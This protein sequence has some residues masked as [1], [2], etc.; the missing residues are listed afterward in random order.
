MSEA[1]QSQQGGLDHDG[2]DAVRVDVRGRA[3]VLEVARAS[4]RNRA[5]DTDRSTTVGNARGELAD[6]A[7][8][9]AT[10][11]T[12]VVVVAVDGDVLLVA[13][14]CGISLANKITNK[15]IG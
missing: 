14:L 11:Q 3:T 6:V 7:S 2:G 4:E 15:D 8:L 13:A 5:R 10:G 9:V 12:E 1:W